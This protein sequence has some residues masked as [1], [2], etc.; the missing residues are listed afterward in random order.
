MLLATPSSPA[1]RG[2]PTCDGSASNTLPPFPAAAATASPP[3]PL[4][5]RSSPAAP[6]FSLFPPRHSPPR[7]PSRHLPPPTTVG[8]P[9]D[10]LLPRT[11]AFR[12]ARL[13]FPFQYNSRSRFSGDPLPVPRALPVQTPLPSAT[14]CCCSALPLLP[15]VPYPTR[16]FSPPPAPSCANPT[17]SGFGSAPHRGAAVVFNI[18]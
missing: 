9:A 6:S 10:T 17:P 18:Y 16:L 8:A 1:L 12:N 5:L 11:V 3:D 7:T 2:K 15:P 13:F 4:F 14:A